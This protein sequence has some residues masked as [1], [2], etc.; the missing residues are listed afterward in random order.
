MTS[1]FALLGRAVTHAA[2]PRFVATFAPG[3]GADAP[4]P[5]GQIACGVV[6]MIAGQPWHVAHIEWPD[7]PPPAPTDRRQ[8]TA[9][10][11]Y[12]ARLMSEAG[13]YFA[14]H[15]RDD[16]IQAMV[17]AR[18]KELG[19]TAYAVAAATG[20]AVCA[21]HVKDYFMRKKS[22]ASHKLQNVLTVLGLTIAKV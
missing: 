7:G 9:G 21:D 3:A 10:A 22:M 18:A 4:Q 1:D 5:G 17:I 13:D 19:M 14:S 11:K 8:A 16:W 6:A 2:R 20:F 12:I 15:V